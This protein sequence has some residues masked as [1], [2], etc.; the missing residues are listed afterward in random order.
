MAQSRP[1]SPL[2]SVIPEES[3]LVLTAE[4]V[5]DVDSCYLSQRSLRLWACVFGASG[6]LIGLLGL[7]ARL[8]GVTILGNF[9]P[10][11]KVIEPSCALSLVAVGA[12]VIRVALVRNADLKRLA[13][14][15]YLL[16]LLQALVLPEHFGLLPIRLT[17]LLLPDRYPAQVDPRASVTAIIGLTLLSS[18]FALWKHWPRRHLAMTLAATAGTIALPSA[19]G[20]VYG[21]PLL[22]ST[23]FSPISAPAAIGLIFIAV[24]VLLVSFSSV[25]AIRACDA[26]AARLRQEATE[27]LAEEL[28]AR[29]DELEAVINSIADGVSITDPTG[30]LIRTN[31]AARRMLRYGGCE[32]AGWNA[33]SRRCRYR[34]A[35][36]IEFAYDDLPLSRSLRGETVTGEIIQMVWPDESFTWVT[37][38]SAPLR[39]KHGKLLGA[40]LTNT[41]MTSLRETQQETQRLL[42]QVQ[43]EREWMFCLLDTLPAY[44]CLIRADHQI[45]YAN[46]RFAELFGSPGEGEKCYEKIVGCDRACANCRAFEP[47]ATGQPAHYEWRHPTRNLVLDV[48]N[49]AFTGLDGSLVSLEVGV[50]V[51]A[52]VVAEQEVQRHRDHL[53]DLISERTARLAQSERQYRELIESAN[54]V[55]LRF[56]ADGYLTLANRYAHELF[57]YGPGEL[58]GKPATI[59]LPESDSSGANPKLIKDALL[60]NPEAWQYNENENITSDGR[61]LWLS[62]SN[63]VSLSEAG[64]PQD[65]LCVG[66]DRTEQHEGEQQLRDY[67]K[68]L[69]ALA[70]EVVNAEQRERQRVATL[71]HDEVAQTLGALKLH[72]SLLPGKWPEA[73][74]DV[75]P[76]IEMSADAVQ[77]TR[78]IMTQLSPPILQRFGV[79][80]ALRWW[81]EVLQEREGLLVRVEAPDAPLRV[82]TVRRTAIFQAVK[83]LLRNVVKHSGATE[84]T[85]TLRSDETTLH[86]EVSDN[87]KGFNPTATKTTATE[88]FGLFGIRERMVH[89]GG[90]MTVFSKPQEGSRIV[91]RLPRAS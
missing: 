21:R 91:L 14:P 41:D 53:E 57:G 60:S 23:S 63:H 20:Y 7:I 54:A 43:A 79:V 81:A 59:I 62:W 37:S 47:L 28:R 16:I 32:E 1:Q 9:I 77:Q 5:V 82:D 90:S 71:L 83:E 49:Y 42:A 33:R 40:V 44:V 22:Y 65:V 67:Q 51:T 12:L 4:V 34:R 10:D 8:T 75:I 80:E 73:A 74:A 85:V 46:G 2:D 50:D 70:S 84:A 35:D 87:G 64:E 3:P 38:S 78:S 30:T 72:L 88:G 39:D 61:L 66:I 86:V 52:R 55:I 45:A 19:L 11:T 68:R 26:H 58:L 15:A 69:R 29:G 18:C 13:V 48:T 25:Q 6:G 56:G 76:L 17:T 89:L 31:D 36:G 24:G 27:R